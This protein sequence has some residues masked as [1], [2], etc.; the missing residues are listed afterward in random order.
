M[1]SLARGRFT[2]PNQGSSALLAHDVN[3]TQPLSGFSD[4]FLG[5]F[6]VALEAQLLRTV[7]FL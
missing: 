7:P 2:Y 3:V 4:S 1:Q 5:F 6:G